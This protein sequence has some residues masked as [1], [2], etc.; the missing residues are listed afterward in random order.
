ML[1]FRNIDVD[2]TLPVEEWGFEGLLAAVDRG[3][4]SDWSKIAASVYADP[5]GPLTDVLAEVLGAAE[6]SGAAGALQAVVELA[7]ERQADH[8]RREV[9]AMVGDLVRRSGLGQAT[10]ARRIGTSRT[11]LNA[12]ISGATTPSA[13]VLLRARRLVDQ[14]DRRG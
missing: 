9:A 4:V 1:R 10:F 3:E 6:D 11:R 14:L 13:R 5:F 12:Y 8:D 7:R 2:P